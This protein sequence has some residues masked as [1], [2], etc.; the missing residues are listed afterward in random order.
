[1][2]DFENDIV[3]SL[4][5]LRNGG[6]ILYPTDTIWGLGCDATDAAAVKKIYDLKQR[7]EAKSLVV[8]MADVK[9]LIKYLASP[10]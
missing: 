1:M 4:E 8:L 5:A 9:D 6:T 3:R 10:P 2:I 7:D